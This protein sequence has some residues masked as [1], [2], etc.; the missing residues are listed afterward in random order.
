MYCGFC[1]KPIEGNVDFCPHCGRAVN[2]AGR[3]SELVEQARGGDQSAVSALY[4]A[5]YSQVYYTVKSMVKD[6]DA[7]FDIVQ[8]S[9]LKAFSNLNRF[10]GGAKFLPWVRK[11]AANTARDWL[12]KKKPL[13]FSELTDTEDTDLS[14]EDRLV[15]ERSAHLPEQV[16]D[17]A[18]T[19]RLIREIIDELPEDQ[20]AAI[21]M[22]YYEEM[23]V[24]QIAEAMGATENA[25]KSRLLYG[26]RKIEKKVDELEQQGT[27][28]YSLSP[29]PFLLWLLRG[30][31]E[32]SGE[33][34]NPQIRSKILS[35]TARMYNTARTAGAAKS[36]SGAAKASGAASTGAKTAAG[37]APA[38]GGFHLGKTIAIVLLALAVVGGGVFGAT[39]LLSRDSA[40]EVPAAEESAAAT[41]EAT[42]ESDLDAALAAYRE[43]IAQAD[44][45]DYGNDPSLQTLGYEY[46][47]EQMLSSD[48]VPTLLLGKMTDFGVEYVRVFRYDPETASVQAPQFPEQ[49]GPLMQGAGSAGGFRGG[50]SILEDG[51]GICATYFSSGT[52]MG[53]MSRVTT[54]GDTLGSTVLWSGNVVTETSPVA[55]RQ[56]DWYPI[57]DQSGFAKW[58]DT[59]TAAAAPTSTPVPTQDPAAA[60][61][62][63]TAA[64][65]AAG[66]IVLNGTVGTYDYDSVVSLQGVP[67]YNG[68]SARGRTWRLIVLT[69]PQT[70]T[71]NNGDGFGSRADEARMI[72]VDGAGIDSAYDGQTVTFSIDPNSTWW[73][74]D[75]SM[76]VGQPGTSDIHIF[77]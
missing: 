24:K 63:W 32:F 50:L 16:I 14:F 31:D 27:K 23:S 71:A 38:A 6:E 65:Q 46:A 25:V 48:T 53:D 17:E 77:G 64:E 21:G 66:R 60:L 34:A 70:I 30:R 42:P 59:D 55:T 73:P 5:T 9:Y 36:A 28:L 39:K 35:E 45:Y 74:S 44:T 29:I 37:A 12:K 72:R 43:I 49:E 33:L 15:E 8:D 47:L 58:S 18:E 40:P 41:P 68:G 69:S 26:R 22:F 62:Q 51:T 1:G 67:D 13:L 3:L 19:R 10:E 4:E 11:I 57:D 75:T 76:P 61:N 56:I 7:V 52:G 54:D 20:R 2:E